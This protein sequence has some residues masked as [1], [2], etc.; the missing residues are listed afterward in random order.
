MTR[1]RFVENGNEVTL[2]TENP[3]GQM[4][5]TTYFVP[6]GG[7]YVRS[8]TGHQ[9]CWGLFS[10]GAALE[11]TPGTLATVIRREWRRQRAYLRAWAEGR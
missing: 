11:A 1:T 9:A 10:N 4:E 5:E 2:I 7:G 3:Y 8:R 6:H